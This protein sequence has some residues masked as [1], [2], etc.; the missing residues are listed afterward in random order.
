MS[1]STECSLTNAEDVY[2]KIVRETQLLEIKF[3][4]EANVLRLLASGRNFSELLPLS[5]FYRRKLIFQKHY[6]HCRVV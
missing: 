4:L 1:L 5:F 3:P 2:R 6:R